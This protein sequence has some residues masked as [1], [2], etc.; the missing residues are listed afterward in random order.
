[1][2]DEKIFATIDDIAKTHPIMALWTL[3]AMYLLKSAP[4]LECLQQA[5]SYTRREIRTALKLLNLGTA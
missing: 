5:R 3:Q 2:T 1:M 4:D